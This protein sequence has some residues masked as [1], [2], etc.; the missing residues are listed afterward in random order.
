MSFSYTV[1]DEL[2]CEIKSKNKKYACL[3]GMLM[4]CKQFDKT[5]ILL[6]TENDKVA[7]KFCSLMDYCTRVENVVEVTVIL[8]KNNTLLYTLCVEDTEIIEKIF[9][10]FHIIDEN[11]IHRINL[12]IISNNIDAF[13]SGAFLSCGSI[14]DPVKEYHLEFVISLYRL[15]NDFMEILID[16]G[17]NV[18]LIERKGQFVIY[19]KESES[20]E[21]ILTLMGSVKSSLELMNIKILKDVRNKAN[22][23]ANCDTANIE[24][25]VDASSRQIKD[26]EYI[27]SVKGLSYLSD[28]LQE[29]AEIRL[30]NPEF[31]LRDICDIMDSKISR[32][33]INH[34]FKKISE[35]A[36]ELR[37]EI[38]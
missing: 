15:A 32:S 1:K 18:K 26:I 30:E 20:I 23:I 25:T 5:R 11:C 35:I 13:I 36:N 10:I 19:L 34:R 38:H 8:K 29:V 37:S 4:F 6:Q 14:I 16:S 12:N 3:Y 31:S 9:D 28:E 2:T 7:E 33:G 27:I 24:K 22:R 21:D 17:I